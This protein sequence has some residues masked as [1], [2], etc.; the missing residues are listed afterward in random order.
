MSSSDNTG[1]GLFDDTA[2]AVGNFPTALRGYDRTAVDDYVRTLEASVV[3][4]RRRATQLE[5]QVSGSAGPGGGQ[6]RQ[7]PGVQ[8]L[9]YSNLGG[10][11]NDILRLA[12][13]QA[14]ELVENAT[15]EAEKV[16]ENA[17]READTLRSSAARE[18]DAIKSGGVAEIDQL[19]EQAARRGPGPGRQGQGRGRGADRCRPPAGG[20]A[21][22]RGRPRGPDHPAERL[23][24]HRE[25]APYGRARGRRDPPAG[26]R[27]ARAGGGPAEAGPTTRPRRG[28][29]RCWPRRPSTTTSRRSGWRPTSPRPPGSAPRRWPRPSRP[30]WRRSRSRR[31]GSPPPR[32]RPPRS[33]S[34][35]SRSS[36]GA[37]SSCGGRPSCCTSASRPCSASWPACRRWPSRP[38]TPSPTWTTRPTWRAT[39]SPATRPCCGPG[40]L[41]TIRAADEI[42]ADD[43]PTE[44]VASTP[45]RTPKATEGKNGGSR[46]GKSAAA[47]A[48]PQAE[49]EVDGDATVLIS[50][51]DAPAGTQHLSG[52]QRRPSGSSSNCRR[53]GTSGSNAAIPVD[54]GAVRTNRDDVTSVR[55][56]AASLSRQRPGYHGSRR[57]ILG[58][59]DRRP[60]SKP[61]RHRCGRAFDRHLGL[62]PRPGDPADGGGAGP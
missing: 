61:D 3:Q 50:S 35:P 37:S 58:Q 32:S 23:P 16:K 20:V 48:S 17:R 12:Q 41:A 18:G 7:G 44:T 10:R 2:S 57:P 8:D 62:G 46:G 54:G 19:R 33:A 26:G 52:G 25:P 31:P 53:R 13:E 38:P 56:L 24:R 30:R 29:P 51:N 36:P 21:P 22:P 55:P 42:P 39:T 5:Q 1:L 60:A 15:I 40:R 49:P 45:A 6:Q 59:I 27:R 11:A 28:P 14:R 43:A 34:G 47:P 9:D 4:S